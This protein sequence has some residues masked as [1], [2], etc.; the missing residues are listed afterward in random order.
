MSEPAKDEPQS[1]D[2]ATTQEKDSNS[3][4]ISTALSASTWNTRIR[5]VLMTHETATLGALG[6][7]M[8]TLVDAVESLKRD[9]V[10]IVKSIETRWIPVESAN[11]TIQKA[12]LTI[13][14]ERGENAMLLSGYRLR[15][16]LAL[17]DHL[18]SENA[19]GKS[20]DPFDYE[21]PEVLSINAVKNVDFE[22]EADDAT[23]ATATAFLNRLS[24][25]KSAITAQEF[26]KYV[27]Y[28]VS[29]SLP[30]KSFDAA[31]TKLLPAKD[32]P[33]ST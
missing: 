16:T 26:V 8:Q 23:K 4:N 14:L 10:A 21:T 20:A 33:A 12:K 30:N 3:V 11:R 24:S 17:F 7:A 22:L 31:F 5:K 2:A 1:G 13:T 32:P 9:K 29:P 18:Q 19:E 28:L 15:R 25:T 27:S 6:Q